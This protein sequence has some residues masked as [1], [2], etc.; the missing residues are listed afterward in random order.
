MTKTT[1]IT[2]TL[3][4]TLGD[5]LA[6][7]DELVAERGRLEAELRVNGQHT[8][9]HKGRADALR[10]LIPEQATTSVDPEPTETAPETALEA[11]PF[12]N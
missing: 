6:K 10:A 5:A 4:A 12:T 8:L 9:Y 3:T 11:D 1:N 7:L 2:D